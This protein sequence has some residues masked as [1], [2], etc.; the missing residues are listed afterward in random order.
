MP[1]LA[2]LLLGS[3]A[4]LQAGLAPHLDLAGGRPNFVLVAV[5]C[6]GILRG[7]RQGVVWAVVG[8]LSLDL[9]SGAPFGIFTL[10]LLGPGLLTSLAEPAVFAAGVTLPALMVGA[11][12]LLAHLVAIL[13]LQASG[14]SVPWLGTLRYFTLPTLLLNA[15][16]TPLVFA[17]LRRLHERTAQPESLYA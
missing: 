2:I 14:L 5:V 12:T 16:L 3:L 1:Y 11:G 6:W 7:R 10:A 15:L 9:L 13:L 4:L 8:G 17:L